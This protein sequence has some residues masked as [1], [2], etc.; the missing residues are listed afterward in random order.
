[1]CCSVLQ[2]VAAMQFVAVLLQCCCNEVLQRVAVCC[3]VVLQC[4]CCSV[5]QL[6]DATCCRVLQCVD[7]FTTGAVG[8]PAVLLSIGTCVCLQTHTHTTSLSQTRTSTHSQPNTPICISVCCCTVL[9]Q[10]VAVFFIFSKYFLPVLWVF[11]RCFSLL[12]LV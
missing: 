2:C 1:M 5:L 7:I 8:I 10:R 3:S 6:V 4:V 9:L 12:A 11:L